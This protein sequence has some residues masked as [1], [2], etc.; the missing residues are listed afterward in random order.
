MG[1]F[2]I[3]HT[4]CIVWNWRLGFVPNSEK[5][6]RKGKREGTWKGQGKMG[7]T[8]TKMER[9]G[10]GEENQREGK[11]EDEGENQTGE[12]KT[13]KGTRIE[14]TEKCEVGEGNT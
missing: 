4:Y 11:G 7:K 6:G 1:I 5:Y 10:Y 9:E 12:V 3:P 8:E 2:D 14:M 13:L